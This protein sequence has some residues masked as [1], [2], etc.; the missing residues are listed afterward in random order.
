M[1]SYPV[2]EAIKLVSLK[3]QYLQEIFFLNGYCWYYKL[4]QLCYRRTEYNKSSLSSSS[5]E[6]KIRNVVM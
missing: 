6:P 1:K 3:I 5:M 4:T 2:W